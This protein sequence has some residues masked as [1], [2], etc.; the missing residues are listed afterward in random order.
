MKRVLSFLLGLVILACPFTALAEDNNYGYDV[1]YHNSVIDCKAATE[2]GKS[3]YM[4]RLGYSDKY[5]DEKFF[6][7]VKTAA[8]NKMNF[9]VYLY[10]YAYT[11][12]EA[13][14]EA[15][16]VINTLSKISGYIDYFTLP[17]AYDLEESSIPANADKAMINKIMTAF[18]DA[19][20]DAGYTAMVYSN[21]S[22]FTNYLDT[23]LIKSKGYKVWYAY[24]PSGTPD[25]SKQI[26]VGS[27]GLYA[28]MWQYKKGDS[29]AGTLDED[30]VFYPSLVI[31]KI[32]CVHSWKTTVIPAE[33]GKNGSIP[34]RCEKCKKAKP[35]TVINAVKSVRFSRASFVYTGKKLTPKPV[36]KDSGGETVNTKYYSVDYKDN[37]E[38]G[39]ATAV[40]SFKDNYKGTKKLK[41]TVEPKGT[42]LSKLSAG[43]RRLTVKWK[44]QKGQSSGHEV[45]CALNNKFSKGKSSKTVKSVKKNSAV[46][47]KLKSGKKYYV[48]VRTYKTVSG[49]K[50]YSSWSK[51]KRIKVK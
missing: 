17:V 43:R 28:D 13:K 5:I 3:F 29:N 48:R 18:C 26:Q 22:W 7:N 30:V 9:G 41:F 44:K 31:K 35:K 10:S 36:I 33:I 12:S 16:F 8:E 50:I 42:K 6:E 51:V 37:A 21:K 20:N 34:V 38:V 24:Y 49:K 11:E 45:Q 25:F 2:N 19:V 14:K 39:T 32:S 46:F 1:S 47:N 15:A 40:V 23:S 4:I 27:T